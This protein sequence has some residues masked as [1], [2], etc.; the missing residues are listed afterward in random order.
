MEVTPLL[1]TA[2]PPRHFVNGTMPARVGMDVME[3]AWAATHCLPCPEVLGSWPTPPCFPHVF[4]IALR[5]PVD[6]I[7][8]EN[9]G[10]ND[11]LAMK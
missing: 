5:F 8:L 3:L 7:I 6:P 2:P 4:W 11:L 10:S 9:L 1:L